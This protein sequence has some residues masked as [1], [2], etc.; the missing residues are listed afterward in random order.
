MLGPGFDIW[1]VGNIG[2]HGVYQTIADRK[3]CHLHEN[4]HCYTAHI[5]NSD[6]H[7][8]ANLNFTYNFTN[9]LCVKMS[10]L[11]NI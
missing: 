1:G 10:F 11:S 4:I 2:Y 5:A 6:S 3:L 9:T 8:R 7:G